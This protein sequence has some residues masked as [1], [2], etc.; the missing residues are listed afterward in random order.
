MDKLFRET[1][2]NIKIYLAKEI[3]EDPY[4]KNTSLTEF[5]PIPIKAI[6]TDLTATQASYKIIGISILK[7]KEIIIKKKYEHMLKMS[8]RI[9]IQGDFYQGWRINGELNYRVEGDYLRA[10]VYI[11]KV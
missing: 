8:Q 2:K 1:S 11:K 9:E 5:N 3:E 7:A 10:Y 6:I 4:E